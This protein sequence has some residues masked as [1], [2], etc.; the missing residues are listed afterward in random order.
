MLEFKRA[1]A[2][3]CLLMCDQRHV[4]K[5]KQPQHIPQHI[6]RYPQHKTGIAYTYPNSK[7][8]QHHL[9][10]LFTKLI[11]FKKQKPHTHPPFLTQAAHALTHASVSVRFVQNPFPKVAPHSLCSPFLKGSLLQICLPF[12]KGLQVPV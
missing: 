6:Y 5:Q 11:V 8:K 1:A 4:A 2:G 10:N 9:Q 3:T 12:P 7:H